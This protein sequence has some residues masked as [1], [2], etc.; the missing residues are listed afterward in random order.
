M[1]TIFGS[2]FY[3]TFLE[4]ADKSWLMISTIFLAGV[5]LLFA[6]QIV[7]INQF[8]FF[9]LLLIA[10]AVLAVQLKIFLDGYIEEMF[11]PIESERTFPLIEAAETIGA[12]V[13]GVLVVSFS[14]QIDTFKFVYFWAISLF[15]MIPFILLISNLNKKVIVV[16]EKHEEEKENLGAENGLIALIKKEF[17]NAKNFS[18]LKGM[19]FLVFFQWLLYNLLEFQY[20]KAIYNSVSNVILDGGS[21]FEH[22]FVHDLG[23][24]FIVFSA[25]ALVLQLFIGSRLIDALG[26]VGSML[27][28]PIVT[29]L[30]L[31]GI[32]VSFNF[33]TAVLAK[34]NFTLT[35]AVFTNA[36]HSGYYAIKE[37]FRE[38][39]R[40]FME[41]IIRPLGAFMGTLILILLQQFLHDK[42]MI[43][44]VNI[45]MI[46]VTGI[47]F[48]VVYV[49][50]N[51]YTEAALD[52][53]LNSK[54]KAVRMNAIDILA[55]R[56]H[57]NSIHVLVG[58]LKDKN[59]SVS[60]KVRTL[61]ALAE[62]H[63]DCVIK[64]II[65]CF[66]ASK[67]AIREAAIDTL[68]LYKDLGTPSK[69]NSVIKYELVEALKKMY[70]TETHEDIR[71]RIIVLLS[72]L[73]NVSTIEF[74]LK[75]LRK[76][77]GDIRADAIHALGNYGDIDVIEF[78]RP[79][80]KSTYKDKIN[81]A[82]VL[83][84]FPEY[85]QEALYVISSFIFSKT[86]EKISYGLYAIG[87]LGLKKFKKICFKH[88]DSKNLQ[89]RMH[90]ALA[91]AKMGNHESI[92]V[93]IDLLFHENK[94]IAKKVKNMLKNVD[95][96]IYKNID[97]I[98]RYIV[99]LEVNKI[100]KKYKVKHLSSLKKEHLEA[101]KWL[102][103]LIEEY[104]EVELINNLI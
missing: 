62:T 33:Y 5:I 39:S 102:Y 95:V 53:L 88:L 28:H 7:Y 80:L 78:V 66:K 1:F 57:S 51:N 94:D 31:I 104:D 98:V 8:L 52:D 12:I 70:E 23:A 92:P 22:A 72:K 2:F 15:L 55:Q 67:A 29:F 87:E 65:E 42:E 85:E 47:F 81:A 73:S 11:T 16:G 63:E 14:N 45:L 103:C 32:V 21:G 36:Y 89:L 9:A 3:S 61:R 71:S 60:V 34:N 18:F 91:L 27:L 40:E 35:T 50:K 37:K 6:A 38:H 101:L 64:D 17:K 46:A 44:A 100:I 77:K 58:I 86:A 99:S 93:L 4:K 25:S 48:Y 43:F 83:G 13:A 68:L 41:G 19:F 84:R 74:L 69:Q 56:G 20:T 76:N 24:L 96:R 79:Y 26:V 49:Q 54:E 82:I 10:E 30:S 90:S 59:E 97:R 75:I